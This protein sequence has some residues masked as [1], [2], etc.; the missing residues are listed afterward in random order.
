MFELIALEW[1]WLLGGP[2]G[3]NWNAVSRNG[4][5]SLVALL[6]SNSI[7]YGLRTTAAAGMGLRA[8]A[9][10]LRGFPLSGTVARRALNSRIDPP[11]A[12]RKRPLEHR[13]LAPSRRHPTAACPSPSAHTPRT[14]L[15]R[16]LVIAEGVRA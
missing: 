7:R 4:R 8:R 10:P 14:G 16:V 9:R 13:A 1:I 15:G 6:L 5:F 3:E 2:C 11:P 12:A